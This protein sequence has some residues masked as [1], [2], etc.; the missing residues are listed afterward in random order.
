[1]LDA[2]LTV[3]RCSPNAAI[4][5]D[6]DTLTMTVYAIRKI[7][8][9]EGVTIAYIDVLHPLTE[10]QRKLQLLYGLACRCERCLLTGD[11]LKQ[12]DEARAKI[13]QWVTDP[14]RLSF[15]GWLEQTAS[16]DVDPKTY[17]EELMTLFQLFK[18]EGLVLRAPLMDITDMLV[19]M[20]IATGKKKKLKARVDAAKSVWA[21]EPRPSAATRRCLE[22]DEWFTNPTEAPEWSTRTTTT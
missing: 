18:P 15:Q 17:D 16:I 14:N 3:S 8:A 19:R 21:L 12:S 9:G 7:K 6:A 5:W 13:R 2:G 1:M 10:R 22:Y 20:A 4:Q 11:P